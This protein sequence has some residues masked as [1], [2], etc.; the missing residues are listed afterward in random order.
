MY[1]YV[2]FHILCMCSYVWEYMWE[3]EVS[4][5]PVPHPPFHYFSFFFCV[6]V[7]CVCKCSGTHATALV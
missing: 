7:D 3:L 1:C 6:Y 5:K 4:I 2:K